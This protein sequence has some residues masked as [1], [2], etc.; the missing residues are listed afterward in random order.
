MKFSD[1][2]KKIIF[3]VLGFIAFQDP[4]LE[5]T[6]NTGLKDICMALRWVKENIANFNGDPNNVTI[7]GQSAGGIATHLLLI[8]PLA[9]GLFQKAIIQSGTYSISSSGSLYF[10]G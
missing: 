3:L 7:W 1:P 5:A 4:T 9:K 6:G 2:S 10:M 8:S